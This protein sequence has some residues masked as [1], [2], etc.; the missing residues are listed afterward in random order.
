VK[1]VRHKTAAEF[2]VQ[3]GNWLEQA[4]AENNLILGIAAFFASYSG[5][6]EIEPYFLTVEDDGAI[7]A[8]ALMTPP[9]RLLIT[10]MS[11]PTAALLA[12]YLLAEGA[13]VPVC[14][15][16]K[17]ALDCLLKI[18]SPKRDHYPV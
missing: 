9:R 17:N 11:N 13:P 1:G 6:L 10:G 7:V 5:Q 8:A 16:L 15:V 12:D 14:W 2:L 3:A 18:G 4:E